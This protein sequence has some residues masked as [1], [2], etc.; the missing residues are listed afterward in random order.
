MEPNDRIWTLIKKKLHLN[1]SERAIYSAAWRYCKQEKERQKQQNSAS[2]KRAS[3]KVTRNQNLPDEDMLISAEWNVDDDTI[4]TATVAGSNSDNDW[5]SEDE[6]SENSTLIKFSIVMPPKKWSTISPRPVEY[7]NNLPGGIQTTR[8]KYVLKQG[9][10]TNAIVTEISKQKKDLPCRFV[11]KNSNVHPFGK[12]YLKMNACCKVCSSLLTGSLKSKPEEDENVRFDF[13]LSNFDIKKHQ[14]SNQ[15]SVKLYGEAA[16]N[17]YSSKESAATIVKKLAHKNLEMFKLPSTPMPSENAV[18]CGQSRLRK[19]EA[20]DDNPLEAINKLQLANDYRNTIRGTGS[21]PY[22]VSYI[23]PEQIAMY[24]EYNKRNVT[25]IKC[26]ASGGFVTKFSEHI[27]FLQLFFSRIFMH[28][29]LIL[30]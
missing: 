19:K 7:E 8:K 21:N 17:I 23:S 13:S 4:D 2:N 11:F 14:M 6:S 25:K 26:D 12:V 30:H 22:F 5:I 9:L 20:L 16:K 28:F 15:G 27:T 29:F 1:L 10:W 18:R 24:K 3:W